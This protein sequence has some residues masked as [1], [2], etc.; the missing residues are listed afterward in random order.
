MESLYEALPTLK[1]LGEENELII[2]KPNRYRAGNT[3]TLAIVKN[4]FDETEFSVD[5]FFMILKRLEK[6]VDEFA[7]V[8]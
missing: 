1:K 4:A 3:A 7:R 6:V 2:D 5:R 8:N